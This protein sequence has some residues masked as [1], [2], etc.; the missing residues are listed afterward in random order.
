MLHTIQEAIKLAGVSRR[1]LYNHSDAGLISFSV[2]PDGRRRYE[3]AELERMYGS[4]APVAHSPAQPNAQ[5]NAQVFTQ[6][7]AVNDDHL[8]AMIEAAVE[9][10]T[11][12]LVAE[13]A[14][15]KAVLM[16]IEHKPDTP[17]APDS[18]V[19]TVPAEAPVR[20][21]ALSSPKSMADV[22]A[23]WE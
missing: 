21:V 4:L 23:G 18:P 17:Q 8:T 15:L 5:P 12:P 3:T 6:P 14:E 20:P 11:A 7:S 16:R 10:A 2:G 19:V 9:R 22:L 13:L 1:T